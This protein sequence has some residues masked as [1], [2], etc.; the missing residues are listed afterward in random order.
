VNS[1]RRELVAVVG[2]T[3]LGAALTLLAV[4]RP[5]AHAVVSEPPLPAQRVDLSGRAVTPLVAAL[6]IVALAAAVAILA[7]RGRWRL[8]VGVVIALAGAAIVGT[9][10]TLSAPDIRSG[11]ALRDRAPAADHRGAVVTIE[12]R[13]WRHVA[14]G[15]GIVLVAAGLLTIA[16]GRALA[17]MGQRYDAP[18][19]TPQRAP[20]PQPA[21]ASRSEDTDLWEQLERGEDPTA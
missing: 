6:G 21:A 11:S 10:A 9:S 14:A 17:T 3:L 20:S 18:T 8:V 2:L 7:T 4:G 5:W 15:G 19:S 12:L 1:G 16:R 13:G